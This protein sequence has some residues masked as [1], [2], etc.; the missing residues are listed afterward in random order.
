[1][2]RP[3]CWLGDYETQI[4]SERNIYHGSNWS[5]GLLLRRQP[6]ATGTASARKADGAECVRCQEWIQ[7]G[8]R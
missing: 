6:S 2:Q 8:E 1:M 4:H 5:G 3:T 7:F